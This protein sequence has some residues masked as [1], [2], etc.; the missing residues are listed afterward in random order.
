MHLA[1]SYGNPTSLVP[2]MVLKQPLSTV[3]PSSQYFVSVVASHPDCIEFFVH[4]DTVIHWFGSVNGT[5]TSPSDSS[6]L[7]VTIRTA[8][9]SNITSVSVKPLPVPTHVG[10]KYYDIVDSIIGQPSRVDQQECRNRC[11]ANTLCCA[12]Q[13]CPGTDAEGCGGC[14]LLSRRPSDSSAEVKHDW[15]AAIERSAPASK[16]GVEECRQWLLVQ[17]SHEKDFFDTSSGKLQRYVDCATV[18]REDKTVSKQVFVGGVHWPTILVANHRNP[19]PRFSASSPIVPHFYV[20]PFYDTNIGNIMKQ[21]SAMNIIQSYEMQSVLRAGEVFVDVGANLGSYTV[22]LAEYLGPSGVVLS[23]EP[24]RWLLQLL[25]A[26]V[27]LNGL[28]NCWTFQIA[29]GANPERQ[30]LLQPN[31]R[32]FSSPGGVRVDRQA[33]VS[34][35]T[36]KQLYDLDWGN[37]AIDTWTLDDVVFNSDLLATRNRRA[38]IDLIKIDVEGMEGNVIRGAE[39]V[40]RDLKPIVWVENVEYFESNKTEF[41]SL[42]RDNAYLCWKSLSAGNDLIC[43]PKTG[44]RSDR[45]NKVNKAHVPWFSETAAPLEFV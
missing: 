25:N 38:Q 42:M 20:V 14:Y 28:M 4:S 26:N 6:R 45:L 18:V 7:S 9:E 16:L 23:F 27:A 11:L 32:W 21:S 31:L 36:M 43:E 15:V 37:E 10:W 41:L 34:A 17:S 30:S 13:V 35:D 1:A 40:L 39:K 33:N 5:W 29:L 12:W 2:G 19:D 22:P 8:C 24:F 3:S 44:E